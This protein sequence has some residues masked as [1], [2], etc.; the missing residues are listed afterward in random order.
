MKQLPLRYWKRSALWSM[1]TLATFWNI[2]RR[3]N[4]INIR[5]LEAELWASADL[6]RAGATLTSNPYCMLD[7]GMTFL[8]YAYSRF[9]LVEPEILKDRPV[10]HGRVLPVEESDFASRSALFLP[11]EAQYSYLVDLPEN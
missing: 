6:L 5:K 1:R 11:R 2:S 3:K 4:M 8:R 10:R 7:L 9:K